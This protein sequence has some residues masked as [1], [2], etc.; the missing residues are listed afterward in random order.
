MTQHFRDEDPKPRKV[1]FYLEVEPFRA[2]Y[3]YI[4]PNSRTLVILLQVNL[5]S[6]DEPEIIYEGFYEIKN[7]SIFAWPL[8][9]GIRHYCWLHY[10]I[11]RL[12]SNNK[13]DYLVLTIRHVLNLLQL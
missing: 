4:S 1:H 12:S 3:Y 7:I 8:I 5:T 10:L 2:G 6:S 13:A 11:H 9:L